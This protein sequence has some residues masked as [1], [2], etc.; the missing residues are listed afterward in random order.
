[1]TTSASTILTVGHSTYEAD[2][3]LS[4][5]RDQGVTAVADVRSVPY[6]RHTPQFNGDVLKNLLGAHSVKYVFLGRELGARSNDPTCYVNGRVQYS[7]L[8]CTELFRSG[9]TR[10]LKGARLERVAL[11][12]AEKEPL[13]CHRAVLI[14]RVLAEMGQEVAHILEGGILEPHSEAMLRLLDTLRL[15]HADLLR[16]TEEMIQ[17]ALARQ[18]ERIAFV[19]STLAAAA[20]A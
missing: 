12:C 4:M 2:T 5:L 3:L 6:S 11:L 17:V 1:M 16:S 18:E 10:V 15:P 14:A 9:I 20:E 19:D 8:A 13:E 7:R